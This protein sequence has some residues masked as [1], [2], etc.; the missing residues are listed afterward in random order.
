MR[1]YRVA[2]M[3]PEG[4]LASAISSMSSLSA[5]RAFSPRWKQLRFDRSRSRCHRAVPSPTGRFHIWGT[6]RYAIEAH[7]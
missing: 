6:M 4:A 3:P 7:L 1:A 2:Q 5:R